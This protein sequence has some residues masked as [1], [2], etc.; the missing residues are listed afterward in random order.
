MSDSEESD[1]DLDDLQDS[2]VSFAIQSGW[3]MLSLASKSPLSHGIAL[4]VTF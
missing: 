4:R 1:S 2:E 3:C